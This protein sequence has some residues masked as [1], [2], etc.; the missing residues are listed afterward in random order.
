MNKNVNKSQNGL[1]VAKSQNFLTRFE[2]VYQLRSE[3]QFYL[4]SLCE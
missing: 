3:I 1:V 4:N 2:R